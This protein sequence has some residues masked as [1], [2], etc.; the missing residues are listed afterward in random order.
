MSVARP[1]YCG[2]MP[3]PRY[4]HGH[5]ESVLRSHQ[6]RTAAN[7]AGFLLADLGT[8][9]RVLDVGCGPGNI[10]ADLAQYVPDGSVVGIDL[11]EEIIARATSDHAATPN[12][13]FR[14]GD[15]YGLD[16]P[17]GSYDVVYAHQVLQHLHDPVAALR[18]MRRVLAPG[19]LLAVR[20]ADFGGF[21]WHPATPAL[22]EWMELYHRVTAHNGAQADGGRHLPQWVR[23]AGFTD[24]AVTATSWTFETAEDR[25][26]WGGLWADR[27][28]LSEFARQA[29]EYSLSTPE[30]LE[31]IAAAFRSWATS[32]DGLFVVP[33]IEVL[34]RP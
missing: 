19:G 11:S 34:A 7:S 15:V 14:V 30:E 5:H 26:W 1:T 17:D 6:W 24:L 20:E 32:E 23:G 31:T 13:S 8:G 28:V 33:S 2:V 10:T 4:T 21:F 9:D 12:V 27:V 16:A 18:E 29:V 25:S 3:T 22:D